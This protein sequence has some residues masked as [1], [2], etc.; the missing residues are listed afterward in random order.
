MTK[1]ILAKISTSVIR[2]TRTYTKLKD[3]TKR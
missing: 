2:I 1:L 3:E